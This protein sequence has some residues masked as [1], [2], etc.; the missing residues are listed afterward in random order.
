MKD[1]RKNGNTGTENAPI[2]DEIYISDDLMILIKNGML[3]EPEVREKI[4]MAKQAELL[5]QHPYEIWEGK[6]GKWRT[7]VYDES[8]PEKEG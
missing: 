6:D 5:A 3:S 4:K 8:K 7:R 1:V 2:E